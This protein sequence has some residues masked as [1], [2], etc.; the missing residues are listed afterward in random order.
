[1]SNLLM[2][3]GNVRGLDSPEGRFLATLLCLGGGL[4]CGVSALRQSILRLRGEVD[5]PGAQIVY[6]W[7]G[8]VMLL[9]FA[10][11]LRF[12]GMAWARW[13]LFA[14]MLGAAGGLGLSAVPHTRASLKGHSTEP[15]VLTARRWVF[16][17]CIAGVAMA[18]LWWR[19]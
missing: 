8:C 4:V 14:C 1:M 3:A 15:P 18:L 9:A 11:G 2:A 17:V 6:K 5:E 7:L 12:E 13:L 10:L 19:R 16:A